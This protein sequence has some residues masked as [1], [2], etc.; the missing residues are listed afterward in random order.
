[1]PAFEHCQKLFLDA[2]RI[3]R[4]ASEHTLRNYGADLQQF[5]EWLRSAGVSDLSSVSNIKLRAYLA[6]LRDQHQYGK[7]TVARKLS[8]LRSLFKFLMAREILREDPTLGLRNPRRE[9]SLPKFLDEP[10][11]AEL[12]DA[13]VCDEPDDA[14][15]VARDRCIFSLLYDCG[16][17][18]SELACMNLDHIDKGRAMVRVLGK[19]KKQRL[20]PLM[21]ATL[22]ALDAWQKLRPNPPRAPHGVAPSA[23]HAVFLNQRGTRLTDRS[24]RRIINKWIVR[25]AIQQRVTPHVLRHSFATHLLNAGAD[26]RDVQELLGHASLSTTQID[27]KSVV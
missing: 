15:T 4:N 22:A 14:W 16:L 7:R 12:L 2:Y 26:L 19:G 6:H 11:T 17:R 27:R 8:S 25:T 21:E 13:P 1:M 20:L 9:R 18:V 10:Q 24:V 23:Q 3:E 5:G